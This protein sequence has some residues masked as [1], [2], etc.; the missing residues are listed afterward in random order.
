MRPLPLTLPDASCP[1]L[2]CHRFVYAH[3]PASPQA[4]LHLILQV[5]P[6][7]SHSADSSDLATPISHLCL[8][9]RNS[10][11][12]PRPQLLV[13][14]SGKCPHKKGQVTGDQASHSGLPNVEQS[15]D[16]L[17]NRRAVCAGDTVQDSMCR[18]PWTLNTAHFKHI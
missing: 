16:I 1:S 12:L 18:L 17:H 4:A 13:L 14:Q 2:A 6:P 10:Q 5:F 3:S 9:S 7:V 8:F 11:A 15:P